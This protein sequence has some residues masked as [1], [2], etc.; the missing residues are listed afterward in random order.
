MGGCVAGGRAE[1]LPARAVCAT[2]TDGYAERVDE[3]PITPQPVNSFHDALG[4]DAVAEF[5]AQMVAVRER[6]GERTVWQVNSTAEGGGV[7]EMLQSVLGYPVDCGI[8]VRWLVIDG[9]DDFFELTK[10]L[11]NLLHGSPGDGGP[12][13]AAERQQY[14]DTLA[15]EAEDILRLVRP[16]DAVVLHDPQTLGLAPALAQRGASVVW[17]CHVGADEPN[18]HTRRAWR[19]LLP[20]TTA[21]GH[22]VFAR[23]QYRWETLDP[24]GV[25]V[26]PPCIDAHSVKNQFL[27]EAQVSAILTAAGV[28]P[29]DASASPSFVRQDGRHSEVTDHAEMIEDGPVPADAQLV[30][31]ISRWDPLKDHRGVLTS[32][33]ENV[34]DD[35]DAHLLLAGP[36]PDAVSDDP[37]G[38]RTFAELH[39]AWTAVE[40]ERRRRLH[41]AC[42]PMTD[43]EQNA[44]I[45]N[46]LQRR[47]DVVVQKSLAEG[48]G[49]TVA[50]AM[51][52]GRATVGSRVGG[53][54][55]QIEHGVSGM[56]AEP[57]D[58]AGFGSAI[59][60][61][62]HD[63]ETA[64]E[65]GRAARE[66]VCAEYLA[67]HYLVRFLKLA[68]AA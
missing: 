61:L 21:T 58:L 36:A 22:Q 35:V 42:L 66:R 51:W 41:L 60:S 56:L 28:V 6:L 57:N 54:Q 65:L 26:I 50:E 19:F 14:D 23:R 67:P 8:R 11:H 46:A 33:C 62:L 5:C 24:A 16:G 55:D 4:T 59:T 68:S 49:L 3:I 10:R 18:E 31:Q 39:A 43:V 30:T 53:I 47:S 7:A 32:F 29:S 27:D 52:K 38:E 12:L 63:R 37:E 2:F 17:S 48:F 1:R 44:A 25:A 9:G 13:T 64:R 45:V 15:S 34:A 20:Y 40:P